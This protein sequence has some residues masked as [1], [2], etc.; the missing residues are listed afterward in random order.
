MY[1]RITFA[2]LMISLIGCTAL[3]KRYGTGAETP[4]LQAARTECRSL[5]DK[6]AAAKYQS[7]FEQEDHSRFIFSDCMEKKGFDRQGKKLK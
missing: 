6:E 7:T 4:E 1:K 2:V 5:A 3:K